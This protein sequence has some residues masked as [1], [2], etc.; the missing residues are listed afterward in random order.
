MIW[1]YQSVVDSSIMCIVVGGT[2]RGSEKP[3]RRV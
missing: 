3:L 1:C 2:E